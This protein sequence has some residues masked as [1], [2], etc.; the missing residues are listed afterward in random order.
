MGRRRK[1]QANRQSTKGSNEPVDSKPAEPSEAESSASGGTKSDSASNERSSP[2]KSSPEKPSPEKL[3]AVIGETG[4]E[5]SDS[6][7]PP[8]NRKQVL[9]PQLPSLSRIMSVVMLVIGILAVGVLFYRLMIGFFVPLF[10]AALLVVIFRPVHLWIFEK[11][12]RRRRLAAGT[13]TALI[14][15][16][17]LLP[18]GVLVS[19]A[20]TQFTI[21]LSKMNLS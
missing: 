6:S 3:S 5:A 19:V 13:T 15:F 16:I 1:N 21:L 14:L 7:V 10:L 11:V 12:G 20:T 8:G 18:L 2:D 9:F 17:V 4:A